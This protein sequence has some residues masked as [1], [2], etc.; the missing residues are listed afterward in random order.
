ML[1]E[2]T[3]V[4]LSTTDKLLDS[5]LHAIAPIINYCFKNKIVVIILQSIQI[6]HCEIN[7]PI[8]LRS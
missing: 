4:L 8:F 6:I 1:P 5:K 3:V 2:N 7:Y